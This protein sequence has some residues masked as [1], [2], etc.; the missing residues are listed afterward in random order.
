MTMFLR[1]EWFNERQFCRWTTD[2]FN[3]LDQLAQDTDIVKVERD[4]VNSKPVGHTHSLVSR[5]LLVFVIIPP[6]VI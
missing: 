3:N 4:E 5:E 2:G 1:Y 6:Q